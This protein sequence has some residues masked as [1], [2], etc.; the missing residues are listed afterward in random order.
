MKE[1][2]LVLASQK[3]AL[4]AF[5]CN[6]VVTLYSFNVYNIRPAC[7][8]MARLNEL[9]RLLLFRQVWKKMKFGLVRA[10]GKRWVSLCSNLT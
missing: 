3:A 5:M 9:I 7:T 4:K 6:I 2:D 8:D 1:L 10:T